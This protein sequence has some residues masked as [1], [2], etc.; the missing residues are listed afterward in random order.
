[1]F[2]LSSTTVFA[3]FNMLSVFIPW[4][5]CM[6]HRSVLPRATWG[7]VFCVTCSLSEVQGT[8]IGRKWDSLL[9]CGIM[10]KNQL[11]IF[12]SRNGT[13]V[14]RWK[15]STMTFGR[16]TS[17]LDSE[18]FAVQPL[19]SQSSWCQGLDNLQGPGCAL[20]SYKGKGL[21]AE[22]HLTT[23]A[24]PND[25]PFLLQNSPGQLADKQACAWKSNRRHWP[26]FLF[27]TT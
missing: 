7:I 18:L 1:M 11:C 12:G 25:P 16:L 5:H 10:G 22:W 14:C 15:E 21:G 9:F 6:F 23:W 2:L 13:Q 24:Q 26:R 8:A 20:C 17:N 3:Y 4:L 19:P 27:Q